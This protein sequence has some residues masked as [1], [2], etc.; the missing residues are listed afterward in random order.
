MGVRRDLAVGEPAHLV[1]DLLERIVEQA[2][3]DR[4]GR[5]RR[6]QLDQSGTVGRRIAGRDRRFER[7]RDPRRHLVGA[8]PDVAQAHD[9]ALAHRNAAEDLGEILGD[10]D[11]HQQVFGLAEAAGVTCTHRVGGK[12]THRL[13]I[14]GKPRKAMG[15]ALLAV[16]HAGD[17]AAIGRDTRP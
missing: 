8:K 15:G 5:L 13:H 14:R 16:E 6:H 12:L 10:P 2:I 1:A 4:R 11:A 3:A 9:L 7:R 17:G